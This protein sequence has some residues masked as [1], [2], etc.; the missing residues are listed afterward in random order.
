MQGL[1]HFEGVVEFWLLVGGGL[2]EGVALVHQGPSI[3][4]APHDLTG[5]FQ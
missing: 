4:V 1:S 2:E 3:I 5:G